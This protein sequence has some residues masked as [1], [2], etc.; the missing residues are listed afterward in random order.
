MS[1]INNI[2]NICL[3]LEDRYFI[4]KI[5]RDYILA[6]KELSKFINMGNNRYIKGI[7]KFK[8]YE[9]IEEFIDIEIG[10]KEDNTINYCRIIIDNVIDKNVNVYFESDTSKRFLNFLTIL[11]LNG[12]EVLPFLIVKETEYSE[13]KKMED[14]YNFLLTNK[15]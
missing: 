8:G 10:V 4:I 11:L 5:N 13:F 12:I 2:E 3:Y 15:L 14:Y 6:K 7:N 1:I 9:M